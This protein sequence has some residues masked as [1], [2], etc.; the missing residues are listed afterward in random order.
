MS[1][2]GRYIMISGFY[3]IVFSSNARLVVFNLKYQSRQ[4]N[5]ISLPN[6]IHSYSRFLSMRLFRVS[7]STRLAPL[8]YS[9]V[10]NEFSLCTTWCY[11]RDL[12]TRRYVC[13]SLSC[14]GRSSCPPLTAR[15][16]FKIYLGKYC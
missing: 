3:P 15:L 16:A 11:F 1:C 13:D 10:P 8:I 14:D 4:L 12:L 6:S 7:R 9:L 5:S 2:P